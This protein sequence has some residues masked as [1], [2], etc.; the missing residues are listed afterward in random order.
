MPYGAAE[1]AEGGYEPGA[2]A[3][4]LAPDAVRP[5]LEASDYGANSPTS[6][7]SRRLSLESRGEWSNVKRI[8]SKVH[9][10][11]FGPNTAVVPRKVSKVMMRGVRF[12]SSS[13]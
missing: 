3:E 8:K 10:E 6:K 1:D 4:D 13:V 2:A 7:G 9:L 5:K 11:V 12:G